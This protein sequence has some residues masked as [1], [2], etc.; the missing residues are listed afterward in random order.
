MWDL[1]GMKIRGNYM[2]SFPVTGKVESSRVKYGGGV[3]HTVVLDKPITV[4]GSTR[5]RILLDNEYVDQ[6]SDN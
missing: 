4:Y 3:Q 1:T 5:E 2:S 6:V